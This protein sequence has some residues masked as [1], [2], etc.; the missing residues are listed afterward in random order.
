MH[1]VNNVNTYRFSKTPRSPILLLEYTNSKPILNLPILR[2]SHQRE[3]VL[4]KS[5]ARGFVT[6]TILA[7]ESGRGSPFRRGAKGTSGRP[8]IT[9]SIKFRPTSPVPSLK[10]SIDDGSEA[11]AGPSNAFISQSPRVNCLRLFACAQKLFFTRGSKGPM[12]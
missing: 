11:P 7:S 9:P 6:L 4:L 10:P 1:P 8:L 5:F 3:R 12:G 2:Q